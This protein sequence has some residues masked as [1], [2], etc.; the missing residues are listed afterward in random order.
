MLIAGM[1]QRINAWLARVGGMFNRL[2]G[3]I[4]MTIGV[5]LPL[6]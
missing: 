1:A 5:M 6:L 3:G 2:C 4:I